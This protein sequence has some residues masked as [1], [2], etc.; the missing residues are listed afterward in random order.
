MIITW[1]IDTM[2]SYHQNIGENVTLHNKTS[3]NLHKNLNNIF[4]GLVF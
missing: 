3:F 1:K 4:G 2:F